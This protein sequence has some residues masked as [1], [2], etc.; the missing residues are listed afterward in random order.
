[1]SGGALRRGLR[2]LAR[3]PGVVGTA[4]LTL[5]VAIG[6]NV[7]LFAAVRGILH[8]LAYPDASRL[9]VPATIWIVSAWR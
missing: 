5:G 9:V 6:A 1:M 3:A 2:R 4:V 7:L 8:P